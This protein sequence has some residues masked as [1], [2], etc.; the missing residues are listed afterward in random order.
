L[1]KNTNNNNRDYYL[2]ILRERKAKWDK[3]ANNVNGHYFENC[4][5]NIMEG[6]R[7]NGKDKRIVKEWE[8]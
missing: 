7:N 4:L 6:Y 3:L 1:R 2:D 5:F 8:R